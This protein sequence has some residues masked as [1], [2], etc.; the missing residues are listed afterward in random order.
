MAHY[1]YLFSEHVTIHEIRFVLNKEQIRD[2][3]KEMQR[4]TLIRLIQHD[5]DYYVPM[6]TKMLFGVEKPGPYYESTDEP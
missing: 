6:A 5:F 3:A 4:N 2:K 1:I